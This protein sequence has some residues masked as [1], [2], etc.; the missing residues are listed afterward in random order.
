M[1][2]QE[3]ARRKAERKQERL[4]RALEEALA[5]GQPVKFV[6]VTG[7]GYPRSF[8]RLHWRIG[9][10]KWCAAE[11]TVG[12]YHDCYS[13]VS[14]MKAWKNKT[15]GFENPAASVTFVE[16]DAATVCEYEWDTSRPA[17]ARAM[18]TIRRY[19]HPAAP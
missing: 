12:S 17:L 15:H 18:T 5:T 8:Y 3:F 9:N 2:Y 4:H 14:L 6:G 13:P 19:V 10:G 16:G 7:I 11:N 1:D